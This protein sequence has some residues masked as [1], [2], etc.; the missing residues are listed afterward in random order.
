MVL[1]LRG[2]AEA[3]QR[4]EVVAFQIREWVVVYSSVE[5][6][7]AFFAGR[8]GGKRGV[9]VLFPAG[10]L[11][12]VAKFGFGSQL[13]AG[14]ASVAEFRA[15]GVRGRAGERISRGLRGRGRLRSRR[16]ML[17]FQTRIAQRGLA[18]KK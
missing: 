15:N 12:P 1:G 13:L 8:F 5:H 2:C 7:V 10:V 3:G 6:G 17:H 11:Y 4:R 18:T 14:I 9:F 16:Y